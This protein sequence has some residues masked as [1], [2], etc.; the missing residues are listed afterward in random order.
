MRNLIGMSVLAAMM[1][2]PNCATTAQAG[3]SV[4]V[5]VGFGVRYA[6]FYYEDIDW[7]NVYV[8]DNSRIGIWIMLPD[9]RWVLR[10]RSMWW[11]S[12]YD[13]W[14]FGPWYYDYSIAYGNFYAWQPYHAIRFH[15]YMHQHYRPWHA[16]YFNHHNGRYIRRHDV[17]HNGGHDAYRHNARR[18]A[19]VVTRQ[20]EPARVTEVRRDGHNERTTVIV[21]EKKQPVRIDGGN[22]PERIEKR[23]PAQVNNSSRS[24]QVDRNNSRSGH[25]D[26]SRPRTGNRESGN[27]GNTVTKTQTRRDGRS[28]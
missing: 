22:R 13:D 10:C 27:R 2:I 7:D 3:A 25:T 5:S 11:N 4:S 20:H 6:N 8:I 28:R 18:N 9:G 24:A 12:D 14:C 15:V 23:Q 19:P 16:R 21:R 26:L 17:R 1:L